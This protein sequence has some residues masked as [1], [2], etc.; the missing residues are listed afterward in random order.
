MHRA[1]SRIEKPPKT[2]KGPESSCPTSPET[3]NPDEFSP[4]L[5]ELLQMLQDGSDKLDLHVS[6]ATP[7]RHGSTSPCAGMASPKHP[8]HPLE[9]S[10]LLLVPRGH[11]SGSPRASCQYVSCRNRHL[12]FALAGPRVTQ[13]IRQPLDLLRLL[14][15]QR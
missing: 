2:C 6:F 3:Y 9:G 12:T 4:E 10:S 11:G 14:R 13:T 8:M 5:Q 1:T 15:R 7:L